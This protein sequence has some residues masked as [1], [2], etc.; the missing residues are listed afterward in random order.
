MSQ[1]LNSVKVYA[2]NTNNLIVLSQLLDKINGQSKLY[3][4]QGKNL[5]K[6]L[7]FD[8]K[9]NDPKAIE[10]KKVLLL[11]TLMAF[12]SKGQ[13]LT[14]TLNGASITKEDVGETNIPTNQLKSYQEALLRVKL[15]N[16]YTYPYRFKKKNS[17]F[18]IQKPPSD[19][20]PKLI[21]SIQ[22]RYNRGLP[23]T[24]KDYLNELQSLNFIPSDKKIVVNVIDFSGRKNQ[25]SSALRS[26]FNSHNLKVLYSQ[27]RK[28]QTVEKS[29]LI[30]VGHNLEKLNYVKGVL[31]I[32]E[33]Y[34]SVDQTNESIDLIFV[35]GKDFNV[36]SGSNK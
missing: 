34:N 2:R 35:M 5:V 4:V 28:N 18:I 13:A 19:N 14:K 16:V 26:Y 12:L 23:Y 24:A 10:T 31:R 15:L 21:E 3:R 27:G 22:N 30:D 8:Q 33:V 36:S 29:Y 7:L 9:A 17:L 32:S 25:Y 11:H 6:Y 1:K 20:Y